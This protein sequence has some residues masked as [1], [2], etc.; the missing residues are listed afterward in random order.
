[1][2]ACASRIP[3]YEPYEKPISAK[4]VGASSDEVEASRFR[5][6]GKRGEEA[7]KPRRCFTSSEKKSSAGEVENPVALTTAESPQFQSLLSLGLSWHGRGSLPSK[8]RKLKVM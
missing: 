4:L 6:S 8:I 5:S 2:R 3:K 1:M 7:S